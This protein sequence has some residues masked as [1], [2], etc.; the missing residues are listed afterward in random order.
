[1]PQQPPRFPLIDGFEFAAAG[2]SLNGR[3]PAGSF[4]RLR[5]VLHDET[6]LVAGL[7]EVEGVLP[8]GGVALSEAGFAGSSMEFDRQTEGME[9]VLEGGEVLFGED[10]GGSHEDGIVAAFQGHEGAAGGNDGFAGTDFAH[11]R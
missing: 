8:G 2:D 11:N 7:V 6:G 10:F 5:E 1:M 4:P 3:W 9:P